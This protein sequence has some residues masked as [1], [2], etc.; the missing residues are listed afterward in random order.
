[1]VYLSFLYYNG[2]NDIL[3]IRKDIY[4]NINCGR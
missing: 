2:K 4:E 1:M 3:F